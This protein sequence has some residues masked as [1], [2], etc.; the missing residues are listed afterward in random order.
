MA[1]VTIFGGTFGDDEA[2]A[3]SVAHILGWRFIGR[4]LLVD[5]AHSC[6]V[7]EA[8]LNDILE[9]EPYFW[10]RWLENLQPYRIALQAALCEAA[11]AGNLVYH[12]HIG[13]ALLS[14]I[15]QVLRV[16]LMAPLEYR[17]AQVRAR[18]GL[19]S[20]A[21]YNYVGQV[22]RARRRRLKAILKT[23]KQNIE[24]FALVVNLAQVSL[25]ATVQTIAATAQLENFRDTDLSLRTLADAALTA[26]V[27]AALLRAH[28]TR[29]LLLNVQAK[30]GSVYVWGDLPI[31]LSEEELKRLV[32]AVFGVTKVVTDF[33]R[34]PSEMLSYG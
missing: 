1:I 32:G 31:A 17:I 3:Q 8:K 30:E 5:A 2:I 10:E 34:T 21:A 9:K 11:L 16:L 4:E 24:Q 33:E 25:P 27:Q 23:Y 14:N 12:G 29:S 28:G 13:H 6:G 7:A 18:Q 15:P 19:D 22:E 20:K 26:R